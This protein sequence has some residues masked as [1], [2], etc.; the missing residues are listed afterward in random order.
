MATH[1]LHTISELGPGNTAWYAL[2]RA[3]RL[4]GL[5]LWRYHFVA[6][7]VAPAAMR[8][9]PGKIVISSVASLAELP[10]DY[11][12][13]REVVAARLRQGGCSIAAWKGRELAATLWYQF[14]AYEEDE[15]R[16]R[17]FLPAPDSCWDYDVFVQPHMRLGMTFCRIWDEAHRRMRARG[18]QWTCSRISAFNPGSLRAHRR[19]GTVHLGSAT[20]I[21]LGRWQLMFA[22]RRPFIHLSAGPGSRPQ[23][24]FDTRALEPGGHPCQPT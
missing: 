14:G 5:Q 23:L 7:R 13:P 19:I 24:V 18:V 4:L 20:F 17:Y 15:V 22:G 9:A 1:L 3:L 16:A 8:S 12:R 21:A 10:P 6:Q 2:A 11:P